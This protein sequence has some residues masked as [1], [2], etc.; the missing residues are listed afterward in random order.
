MIIKITI[1]GIDHYIN[2]YDLDVNQKVILKKEPDNKFDTEAIA[3]YT[4]DFKKIGYI[5]NS[6]STV[7]KGTYSSGR[8]YDKMK[9]QKEATIDVVIHKSAIAIVNIEE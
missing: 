2:V 1:T 4:D 8:L 7:A 3:V 9:D 5:A 6:T